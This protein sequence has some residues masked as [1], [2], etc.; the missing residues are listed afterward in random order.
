MAARWANSHSFA[1]ADMLILGAVQSP[2]VRSL[3]TDQQITW[4]C[5]TVSL[6][7]IFGVASVDAFQLT[8]SYVAIAGLALQLTFHCVANFGKAS[9]R[10]FSWKGCLVLRA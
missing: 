1:S 9:G 8:V 10:C 6:G 2:Y 4:I 3:S 5:G 7:I